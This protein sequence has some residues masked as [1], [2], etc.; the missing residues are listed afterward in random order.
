MFGIGKRATT[1]E[2]NR[3][4]QD[5]LQRRVLERVIEKQKRKT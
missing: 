3:K 5:S 1:L 2:G 4:T